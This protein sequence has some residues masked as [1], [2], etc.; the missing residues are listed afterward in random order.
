MK[1][2]QRTEISTTPSSLIMVD[3]TA[4][5]AIIQM[6][7]RPSRP[8]DIAI[9]ERARHQRTAVNGHFPDPHYL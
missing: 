2:S 3:V 5:H 8:Q 7:A 9:L 6:L 4:L 1:A